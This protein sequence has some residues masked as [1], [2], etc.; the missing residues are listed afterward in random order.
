MALRHL[1]FSYQ[2]PKENV[3]KNKINHLT[4]FPE[5]NQSR[6]FDCIERALSDVTTIICVKSAAVDTHIS[7][8][9]IRGGLWEPTI[10]ANIMKAMEAFPNATFLGD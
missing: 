10:T 5:F 7:G 9:I 1:L 4:E 6:I 3:T 8:S 2:C